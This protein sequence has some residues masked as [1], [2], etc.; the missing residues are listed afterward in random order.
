MGG[1]LV[2]DVSVPSS[3]AYAG[4]V[5]LYGAR[6]VYVLGN[7]A[8]VACYE[9]NSLQIVDISNPA[10]LVLVGSIAHGDG[11]AQLDG[12]WNVFV[13][14]NYAFVVS[15]HSNALE[16]IDVSDPTAPVHAY[17]VADGDNGAR[18]SD[19]RGIFVSNP[20]VYVTS[21]GSNVLKIVGFPISSP[22]PPP[23]LSSVTPQT[24]RNTGPV[25]IKNLTGT[26]FLSGEMV[27]LNRSGYADI[28]AM[29]VVKNPTKK[30]ERK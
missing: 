13:V 4:K 6:N 27:K 26:G 20:Y 16:I 19:P 24:A 15:L 3:P 28:T 2:V 7:F 5:T 25:S 9:S 18:L 17:R 30:A 1:L 10:S 8:Y 11:G 29:N 22:T 12:A 23:P 14:N 21:V